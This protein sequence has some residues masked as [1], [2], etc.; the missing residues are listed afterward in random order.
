MRLCKVQVGMWG[1]LDEFFKNHTEGKNLARQH[2]NLVLSFAKQRFFVY[3]CVWLFEIE[4]YI[5]SNTP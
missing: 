3:L 2:K 1:M 5:N 4:T